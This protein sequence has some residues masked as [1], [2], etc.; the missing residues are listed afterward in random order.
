ML[1]LLFWLYFWFALKIITFQQ[2]QQ[3]YQEVV[4]TR[5]HKLTNS[6]EVLCQMHD[7]SFQIAFIFTIHR[8]ENVVLRELLSISE[9]KIFYI[10]CNSNRNS[11]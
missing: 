4:I 7:E 1:Q 5:E 2:L 10:Q 6:H 11:E 9:A 3:R 8:T